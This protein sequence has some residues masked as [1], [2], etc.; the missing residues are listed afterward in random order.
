MSGTGVISNVPEIEWHPLNSPKDKEV[1]EI[2]VQHGEAVS[3]L[4][5]KKCYRGVL[6]GLNLFKVIIFP[7][8]KITEVKLIFTE[9]SHPSTP[10]LF[11]VN[12]TK[13]TLTCTPLCYIFTI[14]TILFF[15]YM[16]FVLCRAE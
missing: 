5:M 3:G 12:V 10:H 6:V 15:L 2:Q 7:L 13:K 9:F 8:H 16:Y 11:G 4:C 1:N 14:F